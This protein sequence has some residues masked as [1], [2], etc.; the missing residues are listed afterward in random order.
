MADLVDD[1][2][3]EIIAGTRKASSIK[4]AELQKDCKYTACFKYALINELSILFNKLN[5][6]T[7]EV[8]SAAE[9]KWNFY[10]LNQA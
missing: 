2:Y 3:N 5:I 8:L 1:L 6:N 4:V 7:Q 9:S 10:H